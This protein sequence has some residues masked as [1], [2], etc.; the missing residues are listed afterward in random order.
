LRVHLPH[1]VAPPWRR[2]GRSVSCGDLCGSNAAWAAFW[3]SNFNHNHHQRGAGRARADFR[4]L[5]AKTTK[6][7]ATQCY[8]N[9]SK[10]GCSCDIKPALFW[11]VETDQ[12]CS[13]GGG[14]EGA[15]KHALL[16]AVGQR[17]L[18][19][20]LGHRRQLAHVIVCGRWACC[21]VCPNRRPWTTPIRMRLISCFRTL[22]SFTASLAL[23]TPITA[24]RAS[25]PQ[26]LHHT[27]PSLICP[28]SQRLKAI[29][30]ARQHTSS[31][32][33]LQVHWI[34]EEHYSD[35]SVASQR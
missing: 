14:A 35:Y 32:A 34:K 3:H 26:R 31:A 15:V 4:P 21:R 29:A 24:H 18:D 12:T 11:D 19:D 8:L 6:F 13:S 9:E 20:R 17:L 28:P 2:R 22:C 23:S 1:A 16:I 27:F 30:C 10:R 5:C 25:F 7:H 33:I